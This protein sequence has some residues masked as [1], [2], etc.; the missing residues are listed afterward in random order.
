MTRI[1]SNLLEATTGVQYYKDSTGEA[2]ISCMHKQIFVED[3]KTGMRYWKDT[4]DSTTWAEFRHIVR[5]NKINT[6]AELYEFL[7]FTAKYN[8]EEF[9]PKKEFNPFFKV[10]KGE[11]KIKAKNGHFNKTQVKKIL[12]HQDTRVILKA[13]ATDDYLYDNAKDNKPVD[14]FQVL[15]A[16]FNYFD[17][18]T[19]FENGRFGLFVAGMST[20]YEV[21]NKNIILA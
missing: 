21:T 20:L 6:L 15:E 19:T 9:S 1:L 3:L 10:L 12:Q 4:D 5:I 16:V 13:S 11:L 17:A 7:A 14:N 2:K 8:F 18:S